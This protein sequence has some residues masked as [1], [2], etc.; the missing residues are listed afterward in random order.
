[1]ANFRVP[2]LTALLL[3]LGLDPSG[4]PHGMLYSLPS[5]SA[6]AG[7]GLN[8]VGVVCAIASFRRVGAS[9]RHAFAGLAING[10]PCCL[11]GLGV[12]AI[13]F[14][15]AAFSGNGSWIAH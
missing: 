15:I 6:V 10:A 13:A 3:R 2:T 9:R 12:M 5:L 8:A 14:F 4:V 11:A 1:M 7:L